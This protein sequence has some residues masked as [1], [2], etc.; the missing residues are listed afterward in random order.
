MLKRKNRMFVL[1]IFLF[2][3]VILMVG[4]KNVILIST[5]N[6]RERVRRDTM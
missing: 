4:G 3:E 6:K 1:K 2:R 5:E